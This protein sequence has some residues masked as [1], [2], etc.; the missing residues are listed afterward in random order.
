[1]PVNPTS[2][3]VGSIDGK[4]RVEILAPIVMTRNTVLILP[5]DNGG[6]GF[7]LVTDGGGT[8]SWVGL[9]A[10]PPTGPA[11]G[12]LGGNY[13]NPL[14]ISVADVTTGVL[15]RTNGG[16]GLAISGTANQVLG[17]NA[18][19]TALEYKSVV[20]NSTSINIIQGANSIG[21]DVSDLGITTAKLANDAVTFAKMQNSPAN[22][23]L[24]G[25]G[26]AG[27]GTDFT[28]I[29][30]GPTMSMVGTEIN[31]SA[32]NPTGPAGGDLGS[33]YP[34]PTVVSVANVTSGILNTPNGGTGLSSG[35]SGG[36][37]YFSAANT[38]AS[39]AVLTTAALVLGGGGGGALNSLALGTANQMLGMN[40]TATAN[41]YKT[42]TG[43]SAISITH[44]V[45]TV[46]FDVPALSIDTA[47]IA[48]DAVTFPKLL[49]AAANSTLIGSGS[50]GA[51]VDYGP[52]TLDASLLMTGTVLSTVSAP[53]SGAAGG[54]LGSTYPNPTVLSVA[55]ITTGIL[56]VLHGGIGLSAGISGGVPTFTATGAITS[57]ALLTNNAIV[58]G[59]GA[60]AVVKSQALGTANQVLGMNA[61]A[62]ANEYKTLSSAN[63]ILGITNGA[64]SVLFTI[65]S[66]TPVTIGTA[67]SAG[68]GPTVAFSDHVH[69]HG[70]QTS[71]TLHAVATQ[72]VS[73]FM[74]AV[75]KTAFDA[76]AAGNVYVAIRNNTGSTIAKGK[77]VVQN[78][79]F[80]AGIPT[81]VLADKDSA[82]LRPALGVTTEAILTATTGRALVVGTLIGVDTSAWSITDNLV[83]GNSGNFIRPYPV[84][85]GLTTGNAQPVG[86]VQLVN[87][88]TGEISVNVSSEMIEPAGGDL[89]GLYPN[90]TV[91]S[92]A[93]ITTGVL[94]VTHGGTGLTGGTS[95]GINYYSAS[96]TLASSGA[97]AAGSIVLGGG[98][99]ASPTAVAIT[100]G[101]IPYNNGTT[102]ASS[103]ALTSAALVLGGGAGS[104]PTSLALGTAN[105][106]LGMNNAATAHEYKT[107]SAGSARITVTQAANSIAINAATATAVDL[108]TSSTSGAG[109]ATTLVNSDHTHKITVTSFQATDTANATTTSA[110][111][112]VMTTMTLTPGAGDYYVSFSGTVD[113]SSGITRAIT[114]SLYVNGTVVASSVHLQS[115][116]TA[117]TNGVN[118]STIIT[119]VGAGQAV[120][121]R[122][123]VAG[124]VTATV[125]QR[126]LS[127]LKIN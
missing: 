74:S 31:A 6:V 70:A 48:N 51:G 58:L 75:D 40:A 14:V 23:I 19:A 8:L 120:D 106:V 3:T 73:G 124:G 79:S 66:G 20:A 68:A 17:M 123:N 9:N 67:N 119:G 30:L 39:S 1:M 63:T 28:P 83:L 72:S 47:R 50:A 122:W 27:V 5:P 16:T 24:I 34:N 36:V 33:T 69:D 81:V 2:L 94:G 43:T 92:V 37:L 102:I 115:V 103:G 108:S 97:L 93:N 35:V 91:V 109:S 64:N 126:T 4:H 18:A 38:I 71:G 89:S 46:T 60:G 77:L 21:V 112:V 62:T 80:A 22:S 10:L 57:S 44:G 84:G 87:A 41:Q 121:I 86:S 110:T 105:Q 56:T 96:T 99:G 111:D 85:G 45:G 82:T 107:V 95:G 116:A 127:L 12:D 25:A 15:S 53:P 59:G 13:P 125:H 76:L 78:G 52:I 26:S 113:H 88:T 65:T 42:L 101:G 104:S 49:N 54:D 98:A 61:G 55:N 117:V 100:S 7:V 29:T 90:P 114:V 32:T 118:L 11:G